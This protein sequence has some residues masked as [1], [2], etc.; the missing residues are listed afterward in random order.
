MRLEAKK[1]APPPN[2]PTGEPRPP[3]FLESNQPDKTAEQKFGRASPPPPKEI[4]KTELPNESRVGKPR[5]SGEILVERPPLS[6]PLAPPAPKT[7]EPIPIHPLPVTPLGAES[8]KIKAIRTYQSD[9]AENVKGQKTSL[10]RMVIAES[11]RKKKLAEIES[12]TS[13][14]NLFLIA[15]SVIL[16]LGGTL[17]AVYVFNRSREAKTTALTG[18]APALI[19]AEKDKHL[20]VTGLKTERLAAAVG[21]EVA[22]A[23]NKLDTI[24]NISFS[25]TVSGVETPLTT[26]RFFFFLDSR[27]PPAL[28][29]SLDKSFMLGFHTFNGN[30]PFLILR[31]TFYENTFAGMLGWEEYMTR[32]LFPLFNI[33]EDPSSGVFGRPFEDR[34]VKNRDARVLKDDSGRVILFYTFKDKQTLIITTSPDTLEEVTRRLNS[35]KPL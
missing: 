31:T 12:P 27:M 4:P 25:E 30:Q 17:T 34:T 1:V 18:V 21:E 33:R 22:T 10:V 35:A 9:V 2:L 7:P 29:R 20:S 5:T 8:P 16:L 13:K 23:N 3:K 24:E 11:E 15:A 14:L 28:I 6:E 26:E 19:F 32:D